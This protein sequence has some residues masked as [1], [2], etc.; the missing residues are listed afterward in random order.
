[1]WWLAR[2]RAAALERDTGERIVRDGWPMLLPPAGGSKAA[3]LCHP[4]AT[5]NLALQM[6]AWAAAALRAAPAQDSDGAVRVGLH[7]VNGSAQEKTHS[8][9][10]TVGRIAPMSL[11]VSGCAEEEQ[12]TG[13]HGLNHCG[14]LRN[15]GAAQVLRLVAAAI[16]GGDSIEATRGR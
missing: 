12:A 11:F 6:Q 16:P 9:A 8:I 10:C 5:T 14:G 1:M 3:A 2:Q 7:R 15:L 4:S 13:R